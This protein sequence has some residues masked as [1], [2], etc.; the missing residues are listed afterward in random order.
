M[1]RD[2]REAFKLVLLLPLVPFRI[3]LIIL[4]TVV[5]AIVNSTMTIGW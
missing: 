3:L 2:F 1:L 5:L 4:A